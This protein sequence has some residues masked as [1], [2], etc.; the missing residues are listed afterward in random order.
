MTAKPGVVVLT[1]AGISADSGLSTFRGSEGLWQGRRPEDLATPEAWARDPAAVWAF[2]QR[3]RAQLSAVE[4]NAAHRALP[5]FAARL[6][7]AGA[8]VLLV[9]QNVDDL[10]ERAGCTPLHMHGELAWLRCETCGA[11]V[12]DLER[13]DAAAF[14][15]CDACGHRAMRPDVVWFGEVPR[16]LDEIQ[17]ALASCTHFAA[18]GTSGVVYPAAGMLAVARHVGASTWVQAL[19]PPENLTAAD[20]FHRGRAAEVVPAMLDELAAAALGAQGAMG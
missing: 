16:H 7:A 2:Y 18:I 10:H 3:R 14:V 5:A 11:R 6:E 13:V 12:R 1:G 20:R 19:E 4:P 9:T 17:E 8:R 15:P